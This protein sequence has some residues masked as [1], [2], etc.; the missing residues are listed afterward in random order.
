MHSNLSTT[1]REGH[2]ENWSSVDKTNLSGKLLNKM[3]IIKEKIDEIMENQTHILEAIR[4]LD[5]RWK[6]VEDKKGDNQRGEIK[7]ILDS[8]AMLD[9]I[10]VKT[11]DNFL[12]MK[13]TK[14][15]KAIAICLI[16]AKIEK[17]IEEIA[18]LT[19]HWASH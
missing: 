16:D 14:E 5:E 11:S 19:L 18:C 6:N 10:V 9:Q 7:E 8:Q 15:E 2:S 17:F 12:L 13:K 3:D 1:E 4:Y